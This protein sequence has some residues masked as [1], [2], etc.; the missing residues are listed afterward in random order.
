MAAANDT[1]SN[2]SGMQLY[3]TSTFT[4]ILPSTFI[5]GNVS[6]SVSKNVGVLDKI[7]N[8]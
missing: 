1:K 2:N 7:E 6:V 3:F 4:F 5:V 8:T